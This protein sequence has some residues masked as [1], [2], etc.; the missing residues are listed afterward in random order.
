M[1]HLTLIVMLLAG[2]TWTACSTNA[3]SLEDQSIDVDS[4]TQVIGKWQL[5]KT[6]DSHNKR[7]ENQG[8]SVIV[9]NIQENG[10]FI[11]YDT[12]VDPSWKE[13]GL[14]LIEERAAGQWNLD[15]DQLTLNYNKEYEGR[16]EILNI[17]KLTDNELITK[18]QNAKATIYKVYG[19]K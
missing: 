8:L 11:V 2:L 5:T 1:K 18:N 7:N 12:F 17:T 13:K 10:Y 3:D 4:Q 15:G 14:P 19:K 16:K 6:E 9:M